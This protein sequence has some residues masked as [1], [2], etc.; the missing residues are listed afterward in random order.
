MCVTLLADWR[1]GARRVPASRL[2]PASR[3]MGAGVPLQGDTDLLRVV[4]L[5][6]TIDGDGRAHRADRQTS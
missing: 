2:L 6:E 3:L 5:R 4:G 1:V